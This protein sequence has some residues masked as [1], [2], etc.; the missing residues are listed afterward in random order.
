MAYDP[1][2]VRRASA[3]LE[4]NRRARDFYERNGFRPNGD[5]IRQRIGG[6]E[7]TELRYIR[8]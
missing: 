1:N 3:R 6:K 7:L 4:E 5:S 8:N 2:I